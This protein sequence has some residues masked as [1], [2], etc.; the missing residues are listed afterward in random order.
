MR[1]TALLPFLLGF[2]VVCSAQVRTSDL[3]Q[4]EDPRGEVELTVCTQNLENYGVLP[5]VQRRVKNATREDIIDKE[6]ALIKRFMTAKC[7]VIAVQ[8]VIGKNEA[9]VRTV[10]AHLALL[11]QRRTNRFF[12]VRP[13]TSI[14]GVINVGVLVAKDRA[15][16]LNTL[17]YSRVELPKLITKQRPRFFARGPLEVQLD[18]KAVGERIRKTVTLVIFHLKSRAGGARDPTG[19]EWETYRMEEA[20]ALRRIIDNRHAKSFGS[21]EGIFIALGDRNSHFD[22]ASSAILEGVLTLKAFQG[23]AP[24]RLSKRG[25]PLCLKGTS[26]PERLF[27]ALITDPQASKLP[28]TFQLNGVFSWIDDILMPAESLRFALATFDNNG[29]YN[30]GVVYEPREASDHSM[31]YVKLNW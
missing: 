24:C 5:S 8:E 13:G 18:V 22:T 7:D 2:S 14:D 20:E 23:K 3:T 12:D 31:A 16:I 6:A 26:L 15:D 29:D 9:E 10:L 4:V 11:L 17:S 28:G 30:S 1:F 25:I 19:L 21:G 27:S